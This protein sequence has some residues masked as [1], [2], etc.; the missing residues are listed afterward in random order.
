MQMGCFA[1]RQSRNKQDSS[2]TIT[3]TASDPDTGDTHAFGV[4]SGP[5][6]GSASVSGNIL[7]YTPPAN[8]NGTTS[9]SVNTTPGLLIC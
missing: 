7:T 8:W 5:S 9:L 3:L 2:G 6:V 1:Y 4:A